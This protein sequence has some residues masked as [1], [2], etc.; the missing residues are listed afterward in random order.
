ML[1]SPSAAILIDCWDLNTTLTDEL[2][3]NIVNF[4][5]NDE[6]IKTVILASYNCWAERYNQSIWWKNNLNFFSKNQ[7]LRGVRD[8]WHIQSEYYKYSPSATALPEKYTDPI[9][10]NYLNNDKYQIAMTETWELKQYLLENPEIKNVYI[11]G[12][13]WHVCVKLRPLGYDA[14]A[15]IPNINILA[16]RLCLHDELKHPNIDIDQNW[17]S[18]A[19]NIYKYV[20]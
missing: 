14:L 12:A 18:V 16:N 7:S 19:N 10:L 20:I 9:I 1:T 5:N 4:L 15:E 2:H 13:S 17:T 8:M 3:C 11:C 6:N